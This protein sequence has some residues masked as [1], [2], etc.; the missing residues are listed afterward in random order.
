MKKFVLPPILFLGLILRLITIDQSLW[1][2][3]ATSAFRLKWG[4]RPV[5]QTKK[6][7]WGKIASSYEELFKSLIK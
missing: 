6:F 7:D 4:K 5:N 3:E 2:D 1:L